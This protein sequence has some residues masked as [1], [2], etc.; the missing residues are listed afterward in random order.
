LPS[1]TGKSNSFSNFFA[2]TNEPQ[3]S[4]S[5]MQTPFKLYSLAVL[6]KSFSFILESAN[7]LLPF[8]YDV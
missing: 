5:V 2:L 1:N 3:I 4:W 7:P 6:I 8:E